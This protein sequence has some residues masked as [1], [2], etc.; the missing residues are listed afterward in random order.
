MPSGSKHSGEGETIKE[1][2]KKT[3]KAEEMSYVLGKVVLNMVVK[4]SLI[5]KMTV[6]QRL[7]GEGGKS[8]GVTQNKQNK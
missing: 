8:V 5:E 3:N 4:E 6:E 7:V 2:N 1:I